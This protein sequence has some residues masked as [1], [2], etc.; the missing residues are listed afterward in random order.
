M[1]GLRADGKLLPYLPGRNQ[2]DVRSWLLRGRGVYALEGPVHTH[3]VA[4]LDVYRDERLPAWR[5]RPGPSDAAHRGPLRESLLRDDDEVHLAT[6]QEEIPDDGPHSG[7]R[8]VLTTFMTSRLS[9]KLSC[10]ITNPIEARVL[11][12]RA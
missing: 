3:P 7:R 6:R 8:Q 10:L 12:S 9:G 5:R 4:R 1:Q 2:S 11:F